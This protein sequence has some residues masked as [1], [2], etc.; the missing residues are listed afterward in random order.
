[1]CFAS[2]KTPGFFSKEI[3]HV[4]TSRT[5][6]PLPPQGKENAGAGE[7][8]AGQQRSASTSATASGTRAF[9]GAVTGDKKKAQ[10]ALSAVK[11]SPG[12]YPG[13]DSQDILQKA[14]EFGLKIWK[15][16]S[17]PQPPNQVP[18]AIVRC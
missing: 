14:A 18:L 15:I 13:I 4:V 9:L 11:R 1:M 8:A 17:E 7:P 12:S 3:T 16:E 2:Q 10:A 5:T 6:I